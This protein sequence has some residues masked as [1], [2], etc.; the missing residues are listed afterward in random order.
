[1]IVA[2]NTD[3]HKLR[4]VAGIIKSRAMVTAQNFYLGN[5]IK[6]FYI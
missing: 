1:M 2:Q 4:E 6:Y 3:N 5:N